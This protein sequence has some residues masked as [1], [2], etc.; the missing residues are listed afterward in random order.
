MITRPRPKTKIPKYVRKFFPDKYPHRL[1][2]KKA[3]KPFKNQFKSSAEANVWQVFIMHW[4]AEDIVIKP[5]KHWWTVGLF[6][7][8][9]IS[10]ILEE[11][12]V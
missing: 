5:P 11:D 10:K 8:M 12:H 1:N 7:Y 4:L 3:M 2:L 9:S 6:R